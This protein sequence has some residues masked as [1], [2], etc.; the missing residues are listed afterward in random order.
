MSYYAPKSSELNNLYTTGG[1]LGYYDEKTGTL[2]EYQGYYHIY[3]NGLVFTGRNSNDFENKGGKVGSKA[4]E[5]GNQALLY[6]DDST[7]PFLSSNTLSGKT[8]VGLQEKKSPTKIQPRPTLG[9]YDNKFFRRYFYYSSTTSNSE[10]NFEI[11]ETNLNNY[12]KILSS[13]PSL[14][15]IYKAIF[16]SWRLVSSKV[17]EVIKLNKTQ[18][19]VKFSNILSEDKL[20]TF[21]NSVGGYSKWWRRGN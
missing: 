11:G 4:F 15:P 1:I 9:D 2:S 6:L 17:E 12:N 5:V 16:V 10:V 3:Y 18:V 20:Q 7:S 14:K 19:K 21:I 13:D 8:N